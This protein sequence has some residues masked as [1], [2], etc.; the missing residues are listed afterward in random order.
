MNAVKVRDLESFGRNFSF[1][2]PFASPFQDLRTFDSSAN[3]RNV[4]PAAR[5]PPRKNQTQKLGK[6]NPETRG[7]KN[8]FGGQ[9]D[10]YTKMIRTQRNGFLNMS[11]N[12]L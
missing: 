9:F 3:R 5:R 12:V 6:L 7:R 1:K 11:Q 4:P 10:T 2:V 8:I